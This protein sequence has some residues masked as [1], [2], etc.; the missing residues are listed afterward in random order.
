[1][2]LRQNS[3]YRKL[4]VS[5]QQKYTYSLPKSFTTQSVMQEL[6]PEFAEAW[7]RDF[8]HTWAD[9]VKSRNLEEFHRFGHTI[10]GSFMQFGFT[11]LSKV[12]VEVMNDAKREDWDTASKRIDGLLQAMFELKA[13]VTK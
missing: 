10:K 11:E 12:G 8:V 3:A 2:Q 7:I 13:R 1:M 6:L 4:T 5:H 9:V